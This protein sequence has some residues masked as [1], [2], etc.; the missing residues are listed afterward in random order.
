VGFWSAARSAPV[1]WR[2][3]RG[4]RLC[5]VIGVNELLAAAALL[6]VIEGIWPFL[7]PA[8]FRRA[9]QS[10]VAEADGPLRLAGLVSMLA[11]VA[12]LY[13]VN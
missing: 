12:L 9:L 13:L 3:F 11:G 5:A 6:L 1:R 8:T 10:V 2:V 4:C 7:S